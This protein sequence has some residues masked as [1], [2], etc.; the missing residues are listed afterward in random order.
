MSTEVN[1]F[2]DALESNADLLEF[3]DV[4]SLIERHYDFK[5]TAFSNGDQH[6][7]AGQNSGSCKV[8][9]FAKINNL[10]KEQTLQLFAQFYR[11]VVKTPEGE[12]HQNIRQ[13]MLYG[14]ERLSF[15]GNALT[16]KN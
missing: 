4:I 5:E 11:D 3:A 14:Y 10:S 16:E 6:N 15:D 7:E 1:Q 12:D 8:F 9:S 13:F 2:I